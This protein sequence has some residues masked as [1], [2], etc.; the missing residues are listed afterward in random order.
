MDRMSTQ[1]I[2][3]VGIPDVLVWITFGLLILNRDYFKG[4]N[5][6]NIVLK[7]IISSAI[8]LSIVIYIRTIVTSIIYSSMISALL[9]ILVFKFVWGFNKRSSIFIGMLF[10][11]MSSSIENV[12]TPFVIFMSSHSNIFVQSRFLTTLPIRIA[13]II[14]N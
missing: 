10:V 9:Y 14:N 2:L 8:I 13:D 1:D 4:K 3:L 12:F 6:L 11:F 7:Y 5:I